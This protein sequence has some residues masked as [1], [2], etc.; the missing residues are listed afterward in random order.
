MLLEA[1]SPKAFKGYKRD[2]ELNSTFFTP[3]K[4][5]IRGTFTTRAS[6]LLHQGVKNAQVAPRGS[7]DSR[8]IRLAN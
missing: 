8:T 6:T 2:G 1:A 7:I 3:I 5:P 4:I